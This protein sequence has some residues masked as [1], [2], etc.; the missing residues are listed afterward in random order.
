MI[1]A[2]REA[3]MLNG[4][5]FFDEADDLFKEGSY[6]S[7]MLLIQIEK[8]RCVVIFATNKGG[9]IDPAMER[10]LSMKIHFPLP[11]TEQRLKIW[12]ALLPDFVRLAPDVD[13]NLLNNRYPFSGGLIKNTIFLA[14]NSAEPD[15]KGNHI[16]TRQLLE[17]AADLQTK[18]MIESDKFCKTYA[19]VKII[20]NLPLAG[21]QRAELKNMAEAF[22]YAQKKDRDL[23][24]FSAAYFWRPVFMPQMLLPLNVA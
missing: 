15:R 5:V 22:Q 13:L 11:D 2:F 10:R 20:D 8:A 12:Q 21:K 7:R 9:Q 3:A 18:Q 14:A 16:I 6:L 24:F 17:Q 23:I 19:P 4:F 1:Q